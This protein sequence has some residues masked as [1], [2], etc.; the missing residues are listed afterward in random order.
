VSA[1]LTPHPW[2]GSK[3][4][5]PS[6]TKLLIIGESHYEAIDTVN[7]TQNIVETHAI[8]GTKQ[9]FFRGI[10]ELLRSHALYA[11]KST[12]EIWATLAFFNFLPESVA[13]AK[14]RPTHA[15]FSNALASVKRRIA[16]TDPTH[17]AIFTAHGWNSIPNCEG[18]YLEPT[19]EI[20]NWHLKSGTIPCV[21][22]PHPSWGHLRR[23]L[24]A[25]KS[26]QRLAHLLSL[27]S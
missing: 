1:Q 15:A 25:G 22:F 7:Y 10:T 14:S 18:D 23:S 19:R 17:I 8:R 11:N 6:D 12:T 5:N 13:D 2:Q 21:K 3:Y 16:E 4:Q 24:N 27:R 20:F 9:P 26:Q